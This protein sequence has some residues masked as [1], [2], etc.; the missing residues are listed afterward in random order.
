M[1]QDMVDKIGTDGNLLIS[2]GVYQVDNPITLSDGIIVVGHGTT[3]IPQNDDHMFYGDQIENAGI[4][5]LTIKDPNQITSGESSA[6][7]CDSWRS[8]FV[9]AVTV[10]D[11]SMGYRLRTTDEPDD[12]G[13][14]FSTER[15]WFT[16]LESSFTRNCD[17]LIQRGVQDNTFSGLTFWDSPGIGTGGGLR[18]TQA[19]GPIRQAHHG[20]NTFSNVKIVGQHEFGLDIVSW[21]QAW[22]SNLVVDGITN[23]AGIQIRSIGQAP[24]QLFF[25]N[26]WSNVHER[27]GLVIRGHSTDDMARS[28]HLQNLSVGMNGW[29][30]LKLD[31]VADSQLMNATIYN[32]GS[33]SITFDGPVVGC[34]FT[35]QILTDSDWG[36]A[37]NG[38][39]LG[40]DNE[41]A[42][43]RTNNSITGLGTRHV[44]NGVGENGTDDPAVAGEWHEKGQEGIGVIWEK[45]GADKYSLFKGG[46][47]IS[48]T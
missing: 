36:I 6:V 7:A 28:I 13:N 3:L 30:G 17:M 1:F 34:Q 9:D 2:G 21:T 42:T 10:A 16:R 14:S 35:N 20:G 38:N 23:N 39:D 25:N 24:R 22:F 8:C 29:E 15:S 45:D 48:L 37:I 47:W 33:P 41:Y 18:L 12:G 46:R 32:S 4:Y 26:V 5:N 11:Y 19:E 31:H 27:E 44:F 43:V 40:M